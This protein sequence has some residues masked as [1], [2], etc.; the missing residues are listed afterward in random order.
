MTIHDSAIIDEGAFIGEGTKI[1]HWSHVCAGARIGSACSLGQNTY[2]GGR[3]IIGNGV[4]IQNNVS[5]YDNVVIEDD[6]FCGPSVVFTNVYNPRAFISRKH[7]YKTTR[8]QQGA[9]LGANATIVCGV[10]VGR[11]AFLGAGA[12]LTSDVPDFGLYVGSPARLIG[13]MTRE[14]ER[15]PF[16]IDSQ[17]DDPFKDPN[18]GAVYHYHDGQVTL[19]LPPR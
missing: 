8:I 6:V 5:I 3:A 9:T 18:T 12:V 11:F 2:V 4:K 19:E 15:L 17:A 10:T 7:E 13:W 16:A 14:G 1:Y